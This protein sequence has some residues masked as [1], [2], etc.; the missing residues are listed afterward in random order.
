[1]LLPSDDW[2]CTEV[3]KNLFS[4]ENTVHVPAETIQ[5]VEF[6]EMVDITGESYRKHKFSLC[7]NTEFLIVLLVMCVISN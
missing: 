6:R 4:P 1:M 3:S 7:Q 5:L 2:R